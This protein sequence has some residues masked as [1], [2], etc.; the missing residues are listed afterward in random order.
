[1]SK[2]DIT[3]TC[4][5]NA[6]TIKEYIPKDFLK[7]II[8]PIPKGGKDP[9]VMK[10]NRGITLMPVIAKLYEKLLYERYEPWARDN[11]VIDD[12][13]GA[14]QKKCSSLQSTWLLRETIASNLEQGNN[15]YVALLDTAA[16][17]DTV[18][19]D[20]LLV[21]FFNTG[22]EG[23][24]WRIICSFYNCFQCSIRITS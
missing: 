21:K 12:L 5:F 9:T 15:V 1:M 10:N 23:K 13:Q 14:F 18:W 17:Y 7:G 19:I 20:G 6:I 3:L 22:V 8:I 2:I 16:A 24:L 4:L 11:N